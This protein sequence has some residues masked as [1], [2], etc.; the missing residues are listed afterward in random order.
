MYT[1]ERDASERVDTEH[2][3]QRQ[4]KQKVHDT[5]RLGLTEPSTPRHSRLS[6]PSTLTPSMSHPQLHDPHDKRPSR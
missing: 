5:Q 2:K 3:W 1:C 4:G 6:R